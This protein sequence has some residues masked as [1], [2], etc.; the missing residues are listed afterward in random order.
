M[1]CVCWTALTAQ[2]VLPQDFVAP[3]GRVTGH[4]YCADTDRP[5]RL[6]TVT[7]IPDRTGRTDEG[8]NVI[9]VL[10][11]ADGAFIV[12]HL[13]DGFYY[14]IAELPGYLSQ[15][16][17]FTEEQL[18]RPTAA[19]F[20]RM[21]KALTKVRVQQGTSAEVELRLPRGAAVSGGIRYDDGSPAIGVTIQL[22]RQDKEFKWR[23]DAPG[24]AEGVLGA[25]TDDLGRFRISGLVA[26]N[27]ILK[28][29]L[30]Q[31]R[32]SYVG[33]SFGRRFKSWSGLSD[34]LTLEVFS[35]GVFREKDA[36]PIK[37]ISGVETSDADIVVPLDRIYQVSGVLTSLSDGHAIN[38]GRVTLHYKDTGEK[39]SEIE[40]EQDG[41]FRLPFV[42]KGEYTLSA[43]AADV[44]WVGTSSMKLPPVQDYVTSSQPLTVDRDLTEVVVQMQPKPPQ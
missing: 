23:T 10:T 13:R 11:D 9:S 18:S 40:I 30:R 41:S 43:N 3:T 31:G 34:E 16:S 37:L 12:E 6:A 44:V 25:K 5:A 38:S 29:T 39:V 33:G 42:P 20:D 1:F 24:T 7:V 36:K 22:L 26:G 4:V 14:V 32:I 35:G 17:Q 8:E 2:S 15:I 19:I 21:D 27:I 28:C